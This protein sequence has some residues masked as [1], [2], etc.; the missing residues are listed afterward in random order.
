MSLVNL[1]TNQPE[2]KPERTIGENFTK[3]N[4]PTLE[5]LFAILVSNQVINAKS[6]NLIV[7]I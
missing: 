1:S 4:N 6:I 3:T 2:K 7:Y 5:G